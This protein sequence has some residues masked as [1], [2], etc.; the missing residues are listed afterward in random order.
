MSVEDRPSVATRVCGRSSVSGHTWYMAGDR[1]PNEQTT[2]LADQFVFN[3][4][5]K[6]CATESSVQSNPAP[7]NAKGR[8]HPAPASLRPKCGLKT[9]TAKLLSHRCQHLSSFQIRHLCGP[10]V[11]GEHC[12]RCVTLVC[13][14]TNTRAESAATFKTEVVLHPE[15]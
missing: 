6:D 10:A 12:P 3:C 13:E 15:S 1:E 8:G 5:E 9:K 2:S 7:C 11:W 14:A 4:G